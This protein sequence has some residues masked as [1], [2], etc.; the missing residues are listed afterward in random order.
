MC[1]L[2][3]IMLNRNGALQAST[4]IFICQKRTSLFRQILTCYHVTKWYAWQFVGDEL[5]WLAVQKYK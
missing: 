2:S 4:R 3:E 1:V 5:L